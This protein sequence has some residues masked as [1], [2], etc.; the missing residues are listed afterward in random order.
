MYK[1]TH[2]TAELTRSI[3]TPR[4][5]CAK[6]YRSNK[7][8]K[9]K[10]VQCNKA[11][12]A[13]Y[14]LSRS[15]SLFCTCVTPVSPLLM[16]AG[17]ER[18]VGGGSHSS[19]LMSSLSSLSLSVPSPVGTLPYRL[20]SHHRRLFIFTHALLP[21]LSLLFSSLVLLCFALLCFLSFPC[22][23]PHGNRQGTLFAPLA[24]SLPPLC[25]VTGKICQ[26]LFH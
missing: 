5:K 15:L 1:H 7:G 16:T 13:Q 19:Q 21:L 6:Y 9:G 20:M 17:R 12:Q 3:K 18:V 8:T 22:I 10:R 26:L 24:S 25:A 23:G 4:H 14:S 11:M 2:T